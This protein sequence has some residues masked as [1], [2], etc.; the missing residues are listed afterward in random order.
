MTGWKIMVYSCQNFVKIV[1][2]SLFLLTAG[3]KIMNAMLL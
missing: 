1:Q 3:A 2:A